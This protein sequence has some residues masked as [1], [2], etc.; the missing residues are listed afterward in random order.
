M[1][2][3]AVSC[4]A[5]VETADVARGSARPGS[6]STAS[7]ERG[8][9][10]S[11]SLLRCLTRVKLRPPN[12][13]PSITNAGRARTR[14]TKSRPTCSGARSSAAQQDPGSGSPGS[15]RTDAGGTTRSERLIHAAAR[16]ADED[17]G[18]VVVCSRRARNPSSGSRTPALFPPADHGK[19]LA[20]MVLDEILEEIVLSPA[21]GNRNPVA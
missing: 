20:R 11:G 19:R 9:N 6:W 3:F 12:W 1:G 14:T 4:V 2:H 16:Q 21:A 13:R 5:A 7:T 17:F 15:G 18:S 10:S 8:M